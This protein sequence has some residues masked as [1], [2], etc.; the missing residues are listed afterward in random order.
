MLWTKKNRG[1]ARNIRDTQ[2]LSRLLLDESAML[3]LAAASPVRAMSTRV[4]SIVAPAVD[5]AGPDLTPPEA[6]LA[7]DPV[8]E[9]DAPP[10]A[11][12]QRVHAPENLRALCTVGLRSA[13][14]TLVVIR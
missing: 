11:S 10:A 3:A 5:A 4:V 2:R 1:G 9:S 14:I 13:C 7:A 6:S 12:W 8:P